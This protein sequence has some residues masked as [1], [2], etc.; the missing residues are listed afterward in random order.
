MKAGG[1]ATCSFPECDN[2]CSF[3]LSPFTYDADIA[4]DPG[5]LGSSPTIVDAMSRAG[6]QLEEQPGLYRRGRSQVDLL[7]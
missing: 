3:A 4:L 6:F 1:A 7:E 2:A 5:L